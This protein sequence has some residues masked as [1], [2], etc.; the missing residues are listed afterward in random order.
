[1]QVSLLL[2]C[3]NSY[4]IGEDDFQYLQDK[5]WVESYERVG[6]VCGCKVYTVKLNESGED[7]LYGFLGD[8]QL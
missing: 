4:P 6:N 7:V 2:D 8:A 5:G 1:M 3:I